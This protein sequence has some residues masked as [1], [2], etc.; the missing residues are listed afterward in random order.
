M[1]FRSG[2]VGAEV[3]DKIEFA[4][5]K[6]FKRKDIGGDQKEEKKDDEGQKIGLSGTITLPKVP[7]EK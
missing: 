2:P 7:S 6:D 1:L 4:N 3:P 5:R